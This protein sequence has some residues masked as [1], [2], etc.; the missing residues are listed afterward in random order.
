MQQVEQFSPSR[1]FAALSV[2]LTDHRGMEPVH[3]ACFGR[4]ATTDVVSLAYDPVPPE[5]KALT[6]EVV[7]NVQM[8]WEQRHRGSASL[9]L[10][11][12]IAH[13]CDHLG[14]ADDDTPERR[15]G[16]LEREREWLESAAG[17][18]L[19]EQLMDAPRKGTES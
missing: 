15:K 9:E 4:H 3:E 7:V 5:H 11:L 6:G 18:G 12:Y 8:A 16:M 2:I 19:V 13:G 17:R 14:G 10:A 1:E